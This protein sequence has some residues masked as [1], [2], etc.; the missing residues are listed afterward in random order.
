[1]EFTEQGLVLRVGRFREADLW[2]RFLSAR[3]GIVTTFAFGGCRSRR[4]F[5]GC[6]DLLNLVLFRAKSTRNG[7]YLSLQEGTLLNGPQRLRHDWRRVGLAVNCIQFLDALG[8]GPDGAADAFA[9]M[10]DILTVLEADEEPTPLLPVF[11]R[12]ALASTQGYAP[13]F[14]ACSYCGKPAHAVD[15]AWFMVREGG[16]VCPDCP[17]SA[18]SRVGIGRETLD[19]LRF[20]QDNPPLRWSELRLPPAVRRECS[21]AVDGFIQYHIGLAWDNGRFRRL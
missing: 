11:F 14:D 16:F 21:R 4:R 15:E 6:L 9:L 1:M 7:T 18:S 20:V 8:V 2:V 5:C 12:V 10:M 3:R 19:A 13:R 17:P